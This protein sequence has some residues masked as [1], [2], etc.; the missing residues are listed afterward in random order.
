MTVLSKPVPRTRPYSWYEMMEYDIH[1]TYGELLLYWS[2]HHEAY[3]KEM[4]IMRFYSSKHH[5]L[6]AEFS[7]MVGK[8][9]KKFPS[10]YSFLQYRIDFDAAR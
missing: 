6:D 2:V 9:A 7:R 8:R 5:Y 4:D 3:Q 1:Y 10:L